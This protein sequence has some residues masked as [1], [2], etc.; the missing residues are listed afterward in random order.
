[1]CENG[2]KEDFERFSEIFTII[3][4]S[5]FPNKVDPILDHSPEDE[6]KLQEANE[7]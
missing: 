4:K 1:M 7:I 6:R 3:K 2:T 5:L